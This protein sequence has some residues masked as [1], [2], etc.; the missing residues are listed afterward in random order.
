MRNEVRLVTTSDEFPGPLHHGVWE[1]VVPTVATTLQAM[2][3]PRFRPEKMGNSSNE[4]V[5]ASEMNTKCI[6]LSKKC[7]LVFG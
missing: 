6:Q 1:V 4:S 7:M 3:A 5:C 2:T